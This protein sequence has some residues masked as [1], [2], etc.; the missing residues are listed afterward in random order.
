MAGKYRKGRNDG[1]RKERE[2]MGE[3]RKGRNC[4]RIKERNGRW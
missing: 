3:L 2:I 1:R 4:G